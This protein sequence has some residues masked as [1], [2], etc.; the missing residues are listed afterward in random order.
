[1]EVVVVTCLKVVVVVRKVEVVVLEVK[2][3]M[4]MSVSSLRRCRERKT[5]SRRGKGKDI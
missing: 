2:K 1:M 4:V 3:V 5:S